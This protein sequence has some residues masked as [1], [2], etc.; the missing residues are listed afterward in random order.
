MANQLYNPYGSTGISILPEAARLKKIAAKYGNEIADALS[1]PP[2][3]DFADVQA[4]LGL[5]FCP[6]CDE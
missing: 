6:G 1:V 3:D 5:N 4:F 2:D